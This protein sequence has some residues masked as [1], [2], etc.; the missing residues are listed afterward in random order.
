MERR[1]AVIETP[2][3][4][5]LKPTGVDGLPSRLLQNGLADRVSAR[6]AA[7]VEAPPYSFERDLDTLTLNAQA[8]AAWSPML[9]DAIENV[10]DSREFPLILGG[11]CSILLGSALALKRR[12]RFGLLFID[13]HADFYQPEANP[14]GEAASMD[15][16]FA[17]GHGPPLLTNIEDRGPFIRTDDA[18]AFGFRDVDEQRRYGS[19]PLPPDMLALDLMT[20]RHMGVENAAR[21][22]LARM[23]RASLDGFFIHLDAD[24]LNDSIMPCVDYRLPD[25][26]SWDEITSVLTQVL[27]SGRAVG[28]EITIYNPALDEDGTAGRKL[29]NMLVSVLGRSAPGRATDHGLGEPTRRRQ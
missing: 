8:I 17:T 7:R 4:L 24:S 25:G 3:I 16:A 27:A 22:A 19:Q 21:A 28:L 18:V 6:H 29:T 2:S 12:G 14:N 10:L 9:A 20:V 5:G 23:T 1:Y 13:G 11:D 15:L 26:L